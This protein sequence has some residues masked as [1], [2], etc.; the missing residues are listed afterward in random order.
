MEG[1]TLKEVQVFEHFLRQRDKK[2]VRDLSTLL[3]DLNH[4]VLKLQ[5]V[6]ETIE[7]KLDAR[8]ATIVTLQTCISDI[9]S[10]FAKIDYAESK[11]AGIKRKVEEHNTLVSEYGLS[12]QTIS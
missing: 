6:C 3:E 4:L 12:F 5:S 9:L 2:H 11:L 10:V 1:F 7:L 8:K